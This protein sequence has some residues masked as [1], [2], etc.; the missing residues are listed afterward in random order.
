MTTDILLNFLLG[1]GKIANL[2]LQCTVYSQDNMSSELVYPDID[3]AETEADYGETTAQ[4]SQT[5]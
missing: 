3:P 1:Y 5:T 2:F 4:Y